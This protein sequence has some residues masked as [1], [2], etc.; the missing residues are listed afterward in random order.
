[1]GKPFKSELDT[2]PVTYEWA[3][4]QDIEKLSTFIQNSSFLPLITIGSGGSFTTAT[5]AA[6]YHQFIYL[7]SKSITPL[8]Y[9]LNGQINEDHTVF[10]A[11]AGGR[12]HDIKQVFVEAAKEGTERD[13]WRF[14]CL[15]THL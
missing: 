12:N 15:Q 9:S 2:L 5:F 14:A 1:M 4:V 11:S 3:L 6:T 13:S 8:E 10:I 7:F